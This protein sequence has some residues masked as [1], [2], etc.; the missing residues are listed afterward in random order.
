MSNSKRTAVNTQGHRSQSFD[1]G[2]TNNQYEDEPLL[3]AENSI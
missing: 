3:N 1:Y 2:N